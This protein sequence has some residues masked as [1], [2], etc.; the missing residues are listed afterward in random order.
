MQFYLSFHMS[1]I[2]ISLYL[3]AEL[4]KLCTRNLEETTVLSKEEKGTFSEIHNRS[5]TISCYYF[6]PYQKSQTCLMPLYT[7][8][9]VNQIC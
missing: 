8:K 3:S 2:Y 9:E 5:I 7:Y 4:T 1:L 6:L